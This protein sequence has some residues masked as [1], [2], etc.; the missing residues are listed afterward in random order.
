MKN[1]LILFFRIITD[2][3]YYY[4]KNSYYK[5]NFYINILQEIFPKGTDVGLDFRPGFERDLLSNPREIN[6]NIEFDYFTS[7]TQ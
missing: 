7:I 2:F 3:F 4:F 5:E 1:T 6:G